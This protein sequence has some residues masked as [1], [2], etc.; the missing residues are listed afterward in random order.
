[1]SMRK[2]PQQPTYINLESKNPG[3]V[4]DVSEGG[5]RFRVI[6]P[7]EPSWQIHFWFVAD[8][9]RIRGTGVVVWMDETR[10]TGGLRFTHLSGET[11]EQVRSWLS[12]SS[13]QPGASHE[14]TPEFAAP[15]G[16]AAASNCDHGGVPEPA[17]GTGHRLVQPRSAVSPSR[18]K[19]CRPPAPPTD[20]SETSPLPSLGTY[21]QA[22]SRPPYKAIF[23][24]VLVMII[25]ASS[26]I[27]RREAGQ[28][29]VRQ[30][31]RTSEAGKAQTATLASEKVAPQRMTKTSPERTEMNVERSLSPQAPTVEAPL[32][33][34]LAPGEA[35]VVQIAAVRREADTRVL[36]ESLRHKE[37]PVF[38]RHPTL[39]G[40]YRV[41]VGPYPDEEAARITQRELERAG[42]ESFIRH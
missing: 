4:R 16:P 6:D 5:L 40:F 10:K 26:Y 3:I 36:M 2:A 38:V 27:Y 25:A 23:A 32:R 17:Y 29:L 1:M 13:P 35:F 8:S 39:D 11:R 37:L 18:G 30:G 15:D 41:L 31:V 9:N 42:Y 33:E 20:V 22:I 12:A 24:A 14:S 19:R 34:P 28:W 21:V 7:L